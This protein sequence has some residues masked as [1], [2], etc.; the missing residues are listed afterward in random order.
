MI[1]NNSVMV[2]VEGKPTFVRVGSAEVALEKI[3]KI[4][5]RHFKTRP[6]GFEQDGGGLGRYSRGGWVTI[7]ILNISEPLTRTGDEGHS[8]LL[9]SLDLYG[10]EDPSGQYHEGTIYP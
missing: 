1:D 3:T 2:E 5:V 7:S 9:Y 4:Q 8:L 6:E 10:I